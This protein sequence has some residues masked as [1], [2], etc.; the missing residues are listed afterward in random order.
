M[1]FVDSHC[2]L[3]LYDH[4]SEEL[5][6]AESGEVGLLTVTNAPFV[7]PA[8]RDLV[9]RR[10]NVWVAVGLHPELVGKYAPQID[11]LIAYLDE[12]RF[13][14][15]VGIDYRVTD[16]ATHQTQRRTFERIV[17]ASDAKENTVM[18]VHSRGAEADVV[19][20]IGNCFRGTPI[21]H[22]YSGA[23]KNLD[24]AQKQGCYFSINT[25]ML[26]SKNGKKLASRMDQSRVLTET[27]GPF[28]KYN[29]LRARP[30]DVPDVI[31]RLAAI[32]DKDRETVRTMVLEN[33]ASALASD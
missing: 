13:V 23:L 22:W 26:A 3:D 8:C 31:E 30:A 17:E 12:T 1:R 9:A 2:H 5:D 28:A 15:E 19:A 10:T 18:S 11:Y 27:D 20:I 14:G 29:G 16:T 32:W 33:W 7:F 24:V 25:A 21:L 4:P 6:R